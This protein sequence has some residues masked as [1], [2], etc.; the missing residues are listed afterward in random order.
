MDTLEH[1]RRQFDA[2]ED[3]AKLVQTMKALA[4]VNI[5]QGERAVRAVQAYL[6]TVQLGLRALLPADESPPPRPRATPAASEGLVIFGS[7]H[8]L[9]G[10]FNDDLAEY[11][12]AEIARIRRDA[13]SVRLA[14]VGARVAACLEARAIAVPTSLPASA[15]A[16]HARASVRRLL[17]LVDEWRD[18]GI[19]KV[20]LIHMRAVRNGRPRPATRG[21]LPVDLR[22]AAGGGPWP[23]RRRPIHSLS[24]TALLTAI[25]RQYLFA[26]LFRACAESLAAEHTERLAAMQSAEKA[27]GERRDDLVQQIRR[28]RQ[29]RV[30]SELLDVIAGFEVAI[31]EDVKREV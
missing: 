11:A 25:V 4:Q 5:R 6:R 10:R 26:V 15:S 18:E 30:T 22:A 8:G 14:A 2:V 12:D 17:M 9:C 23:S 1:L 27:L 29:E 20:G 7:D 24:R 19:Q 13:A 16:A 3:L 31:E 28:K 21:L